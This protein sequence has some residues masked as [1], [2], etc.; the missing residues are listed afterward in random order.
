VR[1]L[2]FAP[3]SPELAATVEL[4]ARA[5]ID[6]W[7]GDVVEVLHL[8][9]AAE[10]SALTIEITYALRGGEPGGPPQRVVL[11]SPSA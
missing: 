2:L 5:A 4:A 9:V 7:L 1:E 11:R 8:E 10:E 3:N 6:H